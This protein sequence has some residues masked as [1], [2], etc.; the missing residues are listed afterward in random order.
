M[1]APSTPDTTPPGGTPPVSISG[2]YRIRFE[3]RA[4]TCASGAIPSTH[5]IEISVDGSN[6]IVKDHLSGN[7]LTGPG[8]SDGR[9]VVSY[10][11]DDKF[12]HSRELMIGIADG[13]SVSGNF[14][15]YPRADGCVVEYEF[16]GGRR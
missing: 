15:A 6:V 14:F 9:F 7:T 11:K 16:S 4:D 10:S 3:L 2:I 1:R 13:S 8:G 12:F 5:D